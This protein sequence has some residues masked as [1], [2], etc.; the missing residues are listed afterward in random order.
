MV[1]QVTHYDEERSWYAKVTGAVTR[2]RLSAYPTYAAEDVLPT[3]HDPHSL[4]LSEPLAANLS[5]EEVNSL[6]AEQTL[7]LNRNLVL[8][9]DL[10]VE[11]DHDHSYNSYSDDYSDDYSE[12]D[13][14]DWWTSAPRSTKRICL[15]CPVNVQ[16]TVSDQQ[17][18]DHI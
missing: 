18:S 10:K 3:L 5:F 2:N 14:D 1:L 15:L 12:E 11:E 16:Q 6:V 8:A 9:E 13:Y 17:H 4:D 7:Y